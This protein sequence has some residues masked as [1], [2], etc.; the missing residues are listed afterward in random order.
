MNQKTP[1]SK[2]TNEIIAQY[3]IAEFEALHQRAQAHEGI[4]IARTNFFIA[5]TTAVFGGFLL[6]LREYDRDWTLLSVIV[7][8]S[9]LFLLAIGWTIFT[10][11]I[12]SKASIAIY[13]RRA[14]RIRQ[15]FIDNAPNIEIYLPFAPTDARPLLYVPWAPLRHLN[16][17][18]V[19]INAGLLAILSSYILFVLLKERLPTR[20]L[21]LLVSGFGA[22]IFIFAFYL[23]FKFYKDR[24]LAKES[25]EQEK[26][27]V[28]FPI[29]LD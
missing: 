22:S 19:S 29:D 7:I 16:T 11:S 14:G 4:I 15:W 28:H 9:L 27:T 5:L 6:F 23:Q 26:G 13:Y 20:S 18:V 12:D 17:S 8:I 25:D 1:H 2:L 10:Q 24:L 21:L 3:L